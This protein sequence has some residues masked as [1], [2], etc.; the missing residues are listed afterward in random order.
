[1]PTE[2]DVAVI[3]GGPAG[4]SLAILLA[5]RGLRV[6]VFEKDRFP[7]DKLC[8]EFLSGE[9]TRRL[10]E[11]GCL[12]AVLALEPARIHSARF[13]TPSGRSLEVRLPSPALGVSRRALDDLMLRHAGSCGARVLEG[14]DVCSV[15]FAGEA[16]T[17]RPGVE[18]DVRAPAGASPAIDRGAAET[19]RSL[20]AV[21]AHGRRSSLDREL[22]RLYLRAP[23]PYVGLKRHHRPVPGPSGRRLAA[24]LGG[25][26]EIHTF[27]GGYC[28]LSFVERGMVNVCMLVKEGWLK[29]LPSSRWPQL[30]AG[31][32]GASPRL[33][34]R[35]DLLEPAEERV[36]AVAGIPFTLKERCRGPLLFAGD[37]AGTIAPFC[38]DGQAMAL[39]SA[40]HLADLVT[41]AVRSGRTEDLRLDCLARRW[42]QRWRRVFGTRMRL[43]AWLQRLLLNRI[44]AEVSIRAATVLPGLSGLLVRATRGR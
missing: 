27:G 35:L 21:G 14:A 23:H 19:W 6:V 8:G 20:F 44:S 17:T 13:T 24:E 40:F 1:M 32:A 42:E 11:L 12:D 25:V 10:E 34:R 28:G 38:G 33:G 2:F 39:E 37:A 16:G 22:R 15:R 26:V 7:R 9:A 3:G 36:H 29:T 41:S 4:S 5:R 31:L 18:L 43:A 30:R